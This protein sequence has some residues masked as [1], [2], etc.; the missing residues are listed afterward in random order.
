MDGTVAVW[1]EFDYSGD[2]WYSGD[3]SNYFSR[4]PRV[5]IYRYSDNAIVASLGT[6]L[7]L[8]KTGALKTEEYTDFNETQMYFKFTAPS[9]RND[10]V[11]AS[12]YSSFK[13]VEWVK[14]YYMFCVY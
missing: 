5:E 3:S 4:V 12:R 11:N 13:S 2:S 9:E 10:K 7:S 6:S 14:K 1:F 8:P